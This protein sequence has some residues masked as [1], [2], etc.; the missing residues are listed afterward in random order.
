MLGVLGRLG[1]P[2]FFV[3]VPGTGANVDLGL[4][5]ILFGRDSTDKGALYF[6]CV[7]LSNIGVFWRE[8]RAVNCSVVV[9]ALLVDALDCADN[10]RLGVKGAGRTPLDADGVFGTV[11]FRFIEIKVGTPS[12]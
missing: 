10:G 11:V 9:F 6:L 1:V 2:S 8:S 3:G 5:D 7:E 4:N 12:S